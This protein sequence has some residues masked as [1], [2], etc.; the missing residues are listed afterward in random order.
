MNRKLLANCLY[1]F[2]CCWDWQAP[3]VLARQPFSVP[4]LIPTGAPLVGGSIDPHWEITAG[5]GITSPASAFVVTNP[6]R[7]L[8]DEPKFELD[9]G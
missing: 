6:L 4:V 5:P 8:C 1:W 3:L 2:A 9:L 7:L